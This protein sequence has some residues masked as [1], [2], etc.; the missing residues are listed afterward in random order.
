MDMSRAVHEDHR[1]DERVLFVLKAARCPPPR[2]HSSFRL[3]HFF[4]SVK[5]CGVV[6]K[7]R[8]LARGKPKDEV[9]R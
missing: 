2:T 3:R 5:Y 8:S 6:L 1:R 4:A 9:I 7:K